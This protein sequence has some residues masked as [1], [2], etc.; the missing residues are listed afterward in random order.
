MGRGCQLEPPIPASFIAES[1]TV[2]QDWAASARGDLI[3][4]SAT[5]RDPDGVLRARLT[6]RGKRRSMTAAKIAWAVH[7]GDH[8]KGVVKTIGAE[9]DFRR[10]NLTVVPNCAHR[11]WET[12][13]GQASSLKRKAEVDRSLLAAMAD[14]EGAGL[15]QLAK[16]VG[17]GEGRI[18]TKLGKLAER[19]LA[20]SPMC[21]Q[22]RSWA[23]TDQGREIAVAERPLI[24]DLDKQVLAV[25]RSA[26]MG[27]V[28]LSRRLEVCLLTAK[29]RVC[30]LAER[31]LVIPDIRKFYAIT[32]AGI[33][34]LGP[35]AQPPPR[36]VRLELISAAAARDVAE[37]TRLDDR[38]QAERSR[39][40]QMAK[41]AAKR[42]RSYAF[43][44]YT[45]DRIRA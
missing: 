30:L 18:S 14:H 10:E 11:P 44:P 34:A 33:E 22:G 21:V 42:N 32:S 29:R 6:Y 12:G 40:G 20:Q 9:D 8:A 35:E 16:L 37:R 13:G 5:Y 1:F 36:W 7:F 27:P 25:L 23:L 15:A 45:E 31:G 38:T 4:E 28:R 39:P 24:D 3:G 17:I 41:A 26:P 2:R 43:N 19:G